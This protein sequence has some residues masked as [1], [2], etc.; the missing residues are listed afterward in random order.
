M[1]RHWHP[2]NGTCHSKWL[3][4]ASINWHR[5]DLYLFWR[6]LQFIVS[7]NQEQC[8]IVMIIFVKF[9]WLT[10]KIHRGWSNSQRNSWKSDSLCLWEL[11]GG[12][13]NLTKFHPNRR[14]SLCSRLPGPLMDTVLKSW[15]RCTCTYVGQV[16]SLKCGVDHTW[17]RTWAS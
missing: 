8:P 7:C 15:S 4:T 3:E 13:F 9:W 11:L 5:I 16:Y 1:C 6:G 12:S 17:W 14:D 2:L 10:A